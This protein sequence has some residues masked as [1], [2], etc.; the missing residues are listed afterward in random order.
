MNRISTRLPHRIEHLRRAPDSNRILPVKQ[1][2]ASI[3]RT[4]HACLL[5]PSVR[6]ILAYR[7]DN[8]VTARLPT[9]GYGSSRS[10]WDEVRYGPTTSLAGLAPGMS[11]A[12]TR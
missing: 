7:Q 8:A 3:N 4:Q 11:A 5:Q 10:F 9:D 1:D 6:D 12:L 2:V